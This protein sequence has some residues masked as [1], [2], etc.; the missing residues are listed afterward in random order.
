[1]TGPRSSPAGGAL[2]DTAA[3]V[4][5]V[6]TAAEQVADRAGGLAGTL[7]GDVHTL[8]TT[9]GGGPPA[10][11]REAEAHAGTAATALDEAD[12]AL[13]EAVTALQAFTARLT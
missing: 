2:P 3:L 6:V 11:L 10:T 13:R 1:M 4:A 8:L 12:A 5:Q 7:R 9:L